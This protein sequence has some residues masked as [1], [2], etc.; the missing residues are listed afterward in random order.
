MFLPGRSPALFKMGRLISLCMKLNRS[1]IMLLIVVLLA[2]GPRLLTTGAF[3]G[4]WW[5]EGV[6]LGL[7]RNVYLGNGYFINFQQEGFRP[8]A[9]PYLMAGV[10]GLTGMSDVVKWLPPVFG[11]VSVILLFFFVKRMY[12]EA[13][14]FVAALALGTAHQFL[15]FG[16]K[17][18]TETMFVALGIAFLWLYWEA[19]NSKRTYLFAAAGL[20]MA[21]AFLTRYLGFLFGVV[22]LLYPLVAGRKENYKTVFYWAGIAVFVLLL[23]PWMQFG[24]EQF[25]SP[26]G[27]MSV[28]VETVAGGYYLGDWYFYIAHWTEV[29]GLIGLFLVPGMVYLLVRRDEKNWLWLL[30]FILSAV[31]FVALPRKE[32]RYLL[33]FFQLYMVIIALGTVGLSRWVHSRK[34]IPAVAVLFMVVN[35][36]AG[37]QAIA[38]DAQGGLAQVEAGKYLAGIVPEGK[39]I[40]SQSIPVLHYYSGRQIMYFP[41]EQNGFREFLMERNVSHIVLEER[42]PSFPEWVFVTDPA[43]T[44]GARMPSTYWAD[45]ELERTFEENNK[46]IVWVYKA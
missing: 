17:L 21:L 18:L 34:V 6:Y 36:V 35:V 44:K 43:G 9:F 42:E 13:T 41:A 32:A 8:P 14:G 39:T 7:A 45:F 11:I 37:F 38:W 19:A 24:M 23:V 2:A 12:G 27:A 25:G 5:D 22:Y 28:G 15:F 26:V 1:L 33:H 16:A 20:C 40:L 10:W 29:F 4:L 31:M 3:Q 46:T 30:L